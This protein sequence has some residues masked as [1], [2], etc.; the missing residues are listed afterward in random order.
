MKGK[1]NL[2]IFTTVCYQMHMIE[3]VGE[4]ILS[5]N[6]KL[7]MIEYNDILTRRFFLHLDGK[8]KLSEIISKLGISESSAL[9]IVKDFFE[10]K[11]VSI[12]YPSNFD[13]SS[14][15]VSSKNIDNSKLH[16][17]Q[18]LDE[19]LNIILKEYLGPLSIPAVKKDLLAITDM[20]IFE[21]KL[22]SYTKYIT[23]EDD[24]KKYLNEINKY[25]QED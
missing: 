21:D 4:I 19:H 8:R 22:L 18:E 12:V 6:V 16:I 5:K 15:G 9:E 1:V 7:S 13:P 23:D 11:Y 20:K 3:D 2:D 14:L 24:K 10:K 25:L 17:K